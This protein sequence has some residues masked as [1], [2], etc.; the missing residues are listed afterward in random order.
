MISRTLW[1]VALVAAVLGSCLRAQTVR[2]TNL[3]DLPRKQWVDFA[4]PLSD[5]QN[6]PAMCDLGGFVA[7]KGSRVGVHSQMF[8]AY[9]EL[10]PN[11]SLVL[12]LTPVTSD[13]A[14]LPPFLTSPWV[15]DDSVATIP[16]IRVL[17]QGQEHRLEQIRFVQV[18][19]NRAR[20]V[21]HLRARIGTLPLWFD[22]WIYLY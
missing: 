4:V 3:A 9:V 21:F 13:P 6:L 1:R 14:R 17:H 20:R 11:Q 15:D 18:E 19:D 7:L 22:E 2:V 10:L 16:R 8:H 12:P 5:G